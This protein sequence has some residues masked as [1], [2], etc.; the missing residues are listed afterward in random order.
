MYVLPKLATI[1]REII[2][3]TNQ[4]FFSFVAAV[5][6]RYLTRRYIG[7]YSSTSGKCFYLLSRFFFRIIANIKRE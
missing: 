2:S 4:Y 3:E 7:E 5:V 1:I 6:V